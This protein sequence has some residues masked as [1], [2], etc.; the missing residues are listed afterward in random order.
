MKVAHAH[1]IV[2]VLW[3]NMI[4]DQFLIWI[5]SYPLERSQQLTSSQLYAL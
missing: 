5:W 4:P 2:K 3:K 1:T